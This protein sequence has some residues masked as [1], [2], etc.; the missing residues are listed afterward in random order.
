VVVILPTELH[1]YVFDLLALR[2]E[3]CMSKT[4]HCEKWFVE[5]KSNSQFALNLDLTRTASKEICY[6]S[7]ILTRHVCVCLRKKNTSCPLTLYPIYMDGLDFGILLYILPKSLLN[8]VSEFL[9]TNHSTLCNFPCGFMAA[10]LNHKSSCNAMVHKVYRGADKSLA[11]PTSRC[12]LFDGENISFDA[13]LLIY[14]NSNNIPPI[15]I[16]KRIYGNQNLLSL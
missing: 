7:D 10:E 4:A 15:M 9:P 3:T 2:L 8:C 12:I 11:R 5:K 6:V 13:S 1:P 16:I 14:I